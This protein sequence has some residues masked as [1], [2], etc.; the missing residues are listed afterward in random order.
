MRRTPTKKPTDLAGF[1]AR[2]QERAWNALERHGREHRCDIGD[3]CPL[4]LMLRDLWASFYE[5]GMK[6]I[7]V[8]DARELALPSLHPEAY[9]PR[10]RQPLIP[11]PTATLPV[12]DAP[13]QPLGPG[14]L[15]N[16]Q[17]ST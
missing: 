6:Y 16:E 14:S 11:A 9:R 17:R 12:Q 5:P 10:W 13:Q 3:Q 4:R 7:R 2:E 1:I 15:G 8:L